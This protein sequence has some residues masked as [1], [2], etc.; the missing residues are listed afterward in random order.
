VTALWEFL[1]LQ[2]VVRRY[3]YHSIGAALLHVLNGRYSIAVKQSTAGL[4]N[5][6]ICKAFDVIVKISCRAIW[7][8]EFGFDY[9]YYYYYIVIL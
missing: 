5:L 4:L 9:Y 1:Q 8:L 6:H 3:H 7:S 2:S